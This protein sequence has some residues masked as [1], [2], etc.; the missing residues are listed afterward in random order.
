M[1]PATDQHWSK[2]YSQGR[3]FRLISSQ[4]ID[5]FL[6]YLPS[7]AK[8]CLDIGCGTGQLTRELYHRGYSV[9]GVDASQAAIQYARQHTIAPADQLHYI[10][11]DIE[12]TDPDTTQ[13]PYGGFD[14]VTC[15]LVYAFIEDKPTF[16]KK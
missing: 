3:D 7:E 14:L 11:L 13:L 9:V 10:H 8:S 12:S 15:K 5:R 2:I 16:L 1:N 4:A 6:A